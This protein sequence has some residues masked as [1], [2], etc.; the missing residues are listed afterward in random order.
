MRSLATREDSIELVLISLTIELEPPSNPL[1]RLWLLYIDVVKSNLPLKHLT[2]WAGET[3]EMQACV[4]LDGVDR[5]CHHHQ[6]DALRI[7]P[8]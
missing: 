1:H 8:L 5:L 2:L 3:N 6:P 7:S 4:L